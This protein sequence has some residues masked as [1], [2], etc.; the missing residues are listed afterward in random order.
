M[1]C[2]RGVSIT[3]KCPYKYVLSMF[4]DTGRFEARV[5]YHSYSS[6]MRRRGFR[7]RIH[8][9][10]LCLTGLR[11]RPW[12][13]RSFSLWF[14]QYHASL[15]HTKDDGKKRER[16]IFSSDVCDRRWT[17]ANFIFFRDKNLQNNCHKMFGAVNFKKSALFY[18]DYKI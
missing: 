1:G 16:G 17:E 6:E 3:M 4:P 13:F 9:S 11:T 18:A 14:Q 8:G 12:G 2:K 15:S 7:P 10:S 5:S